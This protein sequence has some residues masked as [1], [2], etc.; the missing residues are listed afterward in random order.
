VS[1]S[2]TKSSEIDILRIVFWRVVPAGK[3]FPV[4][5]TDFKA[6]VG[7]AQILS[8][9]ERTRSHAR[10]YLQAHALRQ[11]EEPSPHVLDLAAGSRRNGSTI[12][13]AFPCFNTSMSL[14]CERTGRMPR[15]SDHYGRIENL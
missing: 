14:S 11:K 4:R 9:D 3:K 1:R 12:T 7:K 10:N 5:V 13:V 6:Q 2:G 8:Q 15:L